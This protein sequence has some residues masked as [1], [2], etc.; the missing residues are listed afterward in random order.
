MSVTIS[1]PKLGSLSATSLG[2]AIVFI[3]AGVSTSALL[4]LLSAASVPSLKGI[5]KL[6]EVLSKMD[7]S[8]LAISCASREGWTIP[9]GIEKG[10]AVSIAV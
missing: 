1:L 4:L 7:A 5:E 3:D 6:F 9:A 10:I 2:K 8:L